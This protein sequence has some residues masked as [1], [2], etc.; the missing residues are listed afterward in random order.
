MVERALILANSDQLSIN[1][2]NCSLNASKVEKASIHTLNLQDLETTAIKEA[3]S[4]TNF[5][6]VQAA[7]LLGISNDALFRRIKKYKI[8][9]EKNI[10]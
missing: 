6:Q 10:S 2:F 9:I 8:Q 1:D 4:Q 3:L 7:A 5:N